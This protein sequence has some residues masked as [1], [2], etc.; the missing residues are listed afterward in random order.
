MNFAKFSRKYLYWSLFSIKLKAFKAAV[1]PCELKKIKHTVF[2]EQF[3]PTASYNNNEAEI[4]K[5]YG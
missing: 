2:T 5:K 4:G 3:W 1:F